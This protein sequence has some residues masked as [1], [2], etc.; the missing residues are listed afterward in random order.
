M[1]RA[2]HQRFMMLRAAGFMTRNHRQVCEE[3]GGHPDEVDTDFSRAA[4]ALH[5]YVRWMDDQREGGRDG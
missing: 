3:E 1:D 5:F 2:Q 4:E